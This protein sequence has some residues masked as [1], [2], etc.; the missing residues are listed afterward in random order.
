MRAAG[1]D[2]VARPRSSVKIERLRDFCQSHLVR[3]PRERQMELFLNTVCLLIAVS[4]F[5]WWRGQI[6]NS[7]RARGRRRRDF[8]ELVTLACALAVFLPSVSI[9]DDLHAELAVMEDSSLRRKATSVTSGHAPSQ[10]HSLNSPPALLP[11][12]F[13]P[14][15]LG[16][17]FERPSA[18]G[19][20]LHSSIRA[21]VPSD[22]AP[23]CV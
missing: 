9:T 16:A 3:R 11:R 14:T 2:T 15:A 13:A 4:S 19:T 1:L 10:H 23:P 8:I 18:G 12:H 7:R 17:S 5:V 20:S 6:R 21:R 22:R